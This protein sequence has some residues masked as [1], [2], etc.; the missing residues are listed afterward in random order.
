MLSQQLVDNILKHPHHVNDLYTTLQ[1][2]ITSESDTLGAHG[3]DVVSDFTTIKDIPLGIALTWL[4][5]RSSMPSEAIVTA[6]GHHPT[7]LDEMIA[8]E[9][10]SPRHCAFQ[11]SAQ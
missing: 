9:I 8:F 5:K 2:R 4:S 10:Q 7:V 11:M 6:K 1:Q 3:D